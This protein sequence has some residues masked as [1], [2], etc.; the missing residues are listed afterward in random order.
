MEQAFELITSSNTNEWYT[1]PWIIERARSHMGS[2]D[3]DPASNDIAQQWIRANKYYT[4][5]NDGLQQDWFGNVFLNPPY[6]KTRNVPNAKIWTHRL[7]HFY[8]ELNMVDQAYVVISAK[9]GYKWFM[10]LWK[11]YPNV[12]LDERIHFI[13]EQGEEVGQSKVATTLLYFGHQWDAFE[14]IW[15]DKGKVIFP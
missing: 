11:Q 6:G 13:N 8:R 2:I 4:K 10:E 14:K 5:E 12:T 1:P 3:V 15:S 7:I 9:F